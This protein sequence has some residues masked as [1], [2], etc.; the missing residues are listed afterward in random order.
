[1]NFIE[2]YDYLEENNQK[3][4][5]IGLGD[6]FDI[7]E[8]TLALYYWMKDECI[9]LK[10]FKFRKN[11]FRESSKKRLSSN[12]NNEIIFMI[13]IFDIGY[14][15]YLIKYWNLENHAEYYIVQKNK[16]WLIKKKIAD[17]S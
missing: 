14:N 17:H 13:E 15:Q 1:M 2:L 6:N 11:K 8:R 3:Y 5:F 10:C 12:K 4:N 7:L 9:F 16:P